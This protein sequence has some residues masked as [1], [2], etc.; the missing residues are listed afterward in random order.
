LVHD[1]QWARIAPALP[2][3][4]PGPRRKDDRLILSGIM[5]VL[6]ASDFAVHSTAGIIGEADSIL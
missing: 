1:E 3:N 4:Q 2:A 6:K 5:Q